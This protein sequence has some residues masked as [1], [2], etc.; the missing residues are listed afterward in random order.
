[1]IN[2]SMLN[3]YVLIKPDETFSGRSMLKQLLAM[4]LKPML[5][6][7]LSLDVVPECLRHA[8]TEDPDDINYVG[9][10]RKSSSSPKSNALI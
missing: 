8:F 9:S 2:T 1:M 10:P 4:K 5:L 6:V 3:V 7:S